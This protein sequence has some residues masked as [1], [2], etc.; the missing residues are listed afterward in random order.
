MD[1][2][3]S[4]KKYNKLLGLAIRLREHQNKFRKHWT[5]IDREKSAYY[6]HQLDSFLKKEKEYI[7]SQQGELF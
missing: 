7:N 3:F 1:T 6:G 2:E 5:S 4:Q